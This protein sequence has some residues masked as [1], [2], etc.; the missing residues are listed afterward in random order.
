MI[1]TQ[2]AH[3]APRQPPTFD[4]DDRGG[5]IHQLNVDGG[6][7]SPWQVEWDHT[8]SLEESDEV[9]DSCLMNPFGSHVVLPALRDLVRVERHNGRPRPWHRCSVFGG[10]GHPSFGSTL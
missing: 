5:S 8:H 1:E 4:M 9:K 3:M 2:Q 6:L 7:V 10:I